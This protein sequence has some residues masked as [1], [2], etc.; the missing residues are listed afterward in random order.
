MYRYRMI[1]EH[2][3]IRRRRDALE[4]TQAELGAAVG[5]D[6]LTVS[7]WERGEST[8]RFRYWL[9]LAKVLQVPVKDLSIALTERVTRSG[10]A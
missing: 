4:L 1:D 3:L 5:V 2:D 10:A 7:R 8:P 9:K 6:A